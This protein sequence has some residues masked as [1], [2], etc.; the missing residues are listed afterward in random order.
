MNVEKII[1]S[2]RSVIKTSSNTNWFENIYIPRDDMEE[3]IS[4]LDSSEYLKFT[5]DS[6]ITRSNNKRWDIKYNYYCLALDPRTIV[7]VIFTDFDTPLHCVEVN[8]DNANI[9]MFSR[10]I[11]ASENDLIINAEDLPYPYLEIVDE[12]GFKIVSFD[13]NLAVSSLNNKKISEVLTPVSIDDL[14]NRYSKKLEGID[15]NQNFEKITSIMDVQILNDE[16]EEQIN[17]LQSKLDKT[18]KIQEMIKIINGLYTLSSSEKFHAFNISRDIMKEFISALDPSEYLENIKEGDLYTNTVIREGIPYVNQSL[19]SLHYQY[20]LMLDGERIIELTFTEK[21][22]PPS[23]DTKADETSLNIIEVIGRATTKDKDLPLTPFNNGIIS[24][25]VTPV[26]IIDLAN[27][28]FGKIES[29]NKGEQKVRRLTK[30]TT[31]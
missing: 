2:I 6:F 28:C 17:D 5:G 25:I 19:Q 16:L 23:L 26:S 11:Y 1:E 30:E 31:E 7:V 9:Y 21:I 20:Y 18:K 27:R 8:K 29:L 15:N 4:L 3:F 24:K 14:A 12:K 22:N 13:T 10:K